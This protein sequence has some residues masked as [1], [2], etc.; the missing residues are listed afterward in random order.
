MPQ[1]VLLHEV[2]DYI[3]AHGINFY[4]ILFVSSGLGMCDRLNS[5]WQLQHSEVIVKELNAV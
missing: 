3:G 1:I 2:P 5:H 4:F